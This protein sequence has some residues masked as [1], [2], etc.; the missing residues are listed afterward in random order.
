M[1]DI[2]CVFWFVLMP[3]MV[4]FTL[5]AF[6]NR[7]GI[8]TSEKFNMIQFI[9]CVV[10]SLIP[11]LNLMLFLCL[12]IHACT[13]DYYFGKYEFKWLNKIPFNKG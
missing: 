12:A 3:S 8:Y 2:I 11:L 6:V 5:I 9:A 4:N 13:C 10:A 7:F 1:D